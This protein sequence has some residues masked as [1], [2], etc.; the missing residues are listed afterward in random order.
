MQVPDDMLQVVVVKHTR[1]FCSQTQVDA[2][3]GVWLFLFTDK[4]LR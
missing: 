1:D 4:L 3:S 2:D